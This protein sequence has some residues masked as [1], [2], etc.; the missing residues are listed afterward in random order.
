M[1]CFLKARNCLILFL[2]GSQLCLH[3]VASTAASPPGQEN[4]PE[5]TPCAAP[6]TAES[7]TPQIILRADTLEYTQESQQLTATGQVSLASGDLQLL[8]DQLVVNTATGIGVATGHVRLQ[9]PEDHLEVA[10]L[11]FNLTTE[12]A[13]GY[14]VEG[15]V[16]RHYRVAGERVERLGARQLVVQRGRVTTC[17][18]LLPDWELRA[19]QARLGPKNVVTLQEPSLWIK[20][21]PV[22]Y[23]PYAFIPLRQTRT[24]GFLPPRLGGSRRDGVIAGE[25]FFWAIRDWMDTTVGL[26]YLSERGWRP[27]A[28]W[29]YALTPLSDATL[30]GTFLHDHKTADDLWQVTLQQRQELGAGLRWI[31]QVDQRS[32]RDIVRRFSRDLNREAAVHSDSFGTLTQTL[33]HSSLALTMASYDGIPDSGN[34]TYFRRLP[35]LAFRQ[36]P[37]ALFG[38]PAFLAVETTYDRL[39]ASD[40]R[41]GEAIQRLDVFPSLSIPWSVTPWLHVT[42]TGGVRETVYERDLRDDTYVARTVPDVRLAIEGPLLGRRYGGAHGAVWFHV[43]TPRLHYRY[44][45]HVAQGDLPAFDTLEAET[46]FLDPL[47]TLSLIDRIAATNYAKFSLVQRLLRLATT[48][49]GTRQ[50]REVARLIVSQGMDVREVPEGRAVAPGPLDM[51]IFMLFGERWRLETGFRLQPARGELQE[52]SW[53]LGFTVRP[54]WLLHVESYHR[55]DPDI[56]YVAGGM[57]WAPGAGLQLG[58]SM[59]YDGQEMAFREHLAT[60]LYQAQCWSIDLR[61]RWRHA[62]DTEVLVRANLLQF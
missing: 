26:E 50:L 51:D 31:S 60:L 33:A 44:V 34:D 14:E 45:P 7:A 47:E 6:G 57:R 30:A 37:T 2:L 49:S 3:N 8:A 43:L 22:L 23:L 11:E 21:I 18:G 38:S 41:K 55:Q 24:T 53:S 46:H 29:R 16:A 61:L 12:G 62:G 1:A 54:G 40:V 59:R 48:A 4:V 13:T 35:R 9:T 5:P 25:E 39:S 52:A 56:L 27:S 58:Y 32:E 28:E 20:G 42:A 19:R 36:F 15:K 17:T 10:R